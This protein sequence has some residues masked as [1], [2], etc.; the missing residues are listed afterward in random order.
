MYE[1]RPFDPGDLHEVMSIV[2]REMRYE[3]SPDVYHSIH[4]AWSGG[5]VV[6]TYYRKIVG[7]IMCGVTPAHA[8]RILLLVVR[9]EFTSRGLARK[10]MD[11]MLRKAE[12]RGINTLTL[13]VRVS[14][15]RA[16]R[17]YRT[18]GLRVIRQAKGFYKDGGDALVMEKVLS[19]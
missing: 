2:N 16:I 4:Q 11:V 10:M 12:V 8:L 18:Y 5:F 14:N 9:K 7:F 6:C 13:E 15:D 19:S 1:F 17:F 3:Y